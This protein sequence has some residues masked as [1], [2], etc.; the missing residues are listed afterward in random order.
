VQIK[1]KVRGEKIMPLFIPKSHYVHPDPPIL[2]ASSHQCRVTYFFY[3]ITTN[4]SL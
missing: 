3:T 2:E 1:E 4:E